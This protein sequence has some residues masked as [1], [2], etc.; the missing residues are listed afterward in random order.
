MPS[1]AAPPPRDRPAAET[2]TT[3]AQPQTRPLPTSMMAL[4]AHARGGPEVL[5]YEP[6]PVPVPAVDEVLL[7]VHAASIT[8]AELT[9]DETWQRRG[10]DRTPIVPAHEVSG[11]VAATGGP[12]SGLEVGD[13]VYGLIR[14]DRD[15]AAATYVALPATDLAP[16]PTSTTHVQTAALPLAALTA[17][18][19]LHDHARLE[20]GEDVLVHGG[21]G[22]VGAFAVQL[23]RAAGARVTT[24]ARAADADL[25]R[26]LGAEQVIDFEHEAFDQV[27]HAFDVVLDTVGGTTLDRSFAVLRPGG[28]L[29]TLQAPPSQE[30]AREAGV[31]AVFFIVTP[32]RDQL[33]R[34]AEL[35]DADDLEVLVA[36][37]YPLAAGRQA[38]ESALEP[39]R[40]P[41]KTVL[42]V[43]ATGT[44]RPPAPPEPPATPKD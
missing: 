21:A 7:E 25:V 36:A 9:W 26:R 17:W 23:A 13:K 27:G 39:G 33:V 24:T 11:V 4:R 40:P 38:F 31:S 30:R 32:N 28:R 8:F 43:H 41:G 16:A 35:V 20:P 5:V 1:R 3:A 37:E 29:V 2:P 34:L 14:F 12:G 44:D 19:A 18:Q 10:V 42:V 6:A 15:G 22:G